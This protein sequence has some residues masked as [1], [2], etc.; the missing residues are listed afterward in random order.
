MIT[1]EKAEEIFDKIQGLAREQ[2]IPVILDLVNGKGSEPDPSPLTPSGS[3]P[4]YQKP[5]KRKRSKKPGRKKGHKADFRKIPEKIDKREEHR[6]DSCPHCGTAVKDP[7]EQRQRYI[8]DLPPVQPIVTEHIIYRYWCNCCHKIVEPTLTEALPNSNIGLGVYIYAAWLNKARRISLGNLVVILNQLFH[9]KISPGALAKAWQRF[10]E[11]LQS[12]YDAIG[13]KVKN[14]SVLH[15]DET[16]WRINGITYWLWCFTN[17]LY[18]YYVIDQSRG[19][20]VIK[21]VLGKI[22][23]GTLVCDFW[24]AYNKFVAWAKQRCFFHIFTELEKVDKRNDSVEWEWFR[25]QIYSL[26][27]RAVRLWE[28]KANLSPEQFQRRQANL[29]KHFDRVINIDYNDAD[30]RRLC[31]RFQQHRGELFTFMNLEGVSPYNNHAEQQMRGPVL[32][33]KV[34]QQNRSDKGAAAQAILMTIFRTAELQGENPIQYME[35]LIKSQLL[36]E[37][38]SPKQK[39]Q[40]A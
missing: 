39:V 31:G 19:S 29:E 23:R 10:A 12:E 14:S 2:A 16:G 11:L 22:F 7:V 21:K 37:E 26:L 33:R 6:L 20:I 9:Y 27:Q 30:C 34:C 24:K 15:A 1:W 35:K 5:N 38:T 4:V 18:C 17:K 3:I 32:T 40:A 28:G 8:E 13:E 25:C 36:K